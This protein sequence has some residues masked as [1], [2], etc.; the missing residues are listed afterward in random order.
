[1]F[2]VT[3]KNS[4][5]SCWV[6]KCDI[7]KFFASIDHGILLKIVARKIADKDINLLLQEIIYSFDLHIKHNLGVRH[8]IR[9]ADD[10]CILSSDRNY[11]SGLILEFAD[12]LSTELRLSL[13]PSKVIIRAFSSGIDF[14]GWVNFPTHRVLRTATR[15]R[16][17]RRI[18]L[19]PA[20]ETLQSYLGM[21]KHGNAGK[22][23][24]DILSNFW[25][26]GSSAML[27]LQSPENLL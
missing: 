23:R 7:R 3:S 6:L 18:A 14:L 10:F 2:Y 21:L 4:H 11:L 8:Y 12:Y 27:S 22:I 20:N 9:Y 16:I 19:K 1:M 26:A 13:H 17:M 15:K 24:Q 5:K 25:L